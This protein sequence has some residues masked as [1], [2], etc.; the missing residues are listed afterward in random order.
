VICSILHFILVIM[1]SRFDDEEKA[2][3]AIR[4]SV[5]AI[6]ASTDTGRTDRT[7]NTFGRAH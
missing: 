1:M 5:E 7:G 2:V 3:G 6:R 4:A